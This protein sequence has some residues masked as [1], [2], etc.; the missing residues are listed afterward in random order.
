MRPAAPPGAL[1]PANA[2]TPCVADDVELPLYSTTRAANDH[3]RTERF[4][5]ADRP[6]HADG[7]TDAALLD[8]GAAAF[9]NPGTRLP[10]GAAETPWRAA[11]RLPRHAGPRRRHR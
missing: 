9:G 8:S 6:R 5:H 3:A 4:P 2:S 7:C 10:A 11:H 1:R